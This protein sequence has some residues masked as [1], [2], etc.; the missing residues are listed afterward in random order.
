MFLNIFHLLSVSKNGRTDESSSNV[1]PW[2]LWQ[3]WKARNSFIFNKHMVQPHR[4]VSHA[5]EDAKLWKQAQVPHLETESPKNTKKWRK[6]PQGY[7][8]CNIGSS[9]ISADKACG[10]SW[11]LRDS[12]GNPILHSRRAYSYIRSKEEANLYAMLWAV[13]SMSNLH[14]HNILFEASEMRKEILC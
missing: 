11:I 4:I 13:E 8:K 10:V 6:P 5:Y 9:W 1:F 7:V 14:K 2:L 12:T 3:I